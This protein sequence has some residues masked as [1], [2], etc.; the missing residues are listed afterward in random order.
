MLSGLDKLVDEQA[1]E[2]PTNNKDSGSDFKQ[3]T[4]HDDARSAKDIFQNV[5]PSLACDEGQSA[6][7]FAPD[8]V[9]EH[10]MD[11][12]LKMT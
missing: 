3:A 9:A 2:Q 4:M 10:A 7:T 11:N 12:V 8:V 5:R 6:E 1:M